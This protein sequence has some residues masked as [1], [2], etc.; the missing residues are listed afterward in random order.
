ML[1]QVD[2]PWT[3]CPCLLVLLV[4]HGRLK[5]SKLFPK[6]GLVVYWTANECQ[7][8]NRRGRHQCQ[9]HSPVEE[10]HLECQIHSLLEE[11]DL[12]PHTHSQ[13]SVQEWSDCGS[14][15]FALSVQVELADCGSL[16]SSPAAFFS[17]WMTWASRWLFFSSCLLDDLSF[18][19]TKRSVATAVMLNIK[20]IQAM[21]GFW[22]WYIAHILY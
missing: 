11:D 4:S 8:Q 14:Q 20:R 12:W 6:A 21:G 13:T 10:Y 7:M 19:V 5:D 17:C 22:R 16:P 18:K 15:K 2:T 3:L 1:V 9:I